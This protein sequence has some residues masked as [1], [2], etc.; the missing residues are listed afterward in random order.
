MPDDLFLLVKSNSACTRPA[1][2]KSLTAST[3]PLS[4]A[5]MSGVL[6]SPSFPSGSTPFA[7]SNRI[8]CVRPHCAALTSVVTPC[9]LGK[10]GPTLSLARSAFTTSVCPAKTALNKARSPKLGSW[11]GST[12][13][14]A[15]RNFTIPACPFRAAASRGLSPLWDLA[16][17]SASTRAIA[18]RRLTIP[19]CPFRAA[20]MSGACPNS[21]FEFAST[22]P[23]RS[24][25]STTS[26][27]PAA[28]ANARGVSPR[29]VRRSGWMSFADSNS[30]T[31]AR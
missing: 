13:G 16:S 7:S 22:F 20:A 14:I 21:S 12:V 26:S 24:N 1:E 23:V 18:R 19:I 17:A 6:P 8:I 4:A 31:T 15:R 5:I 10:L 30:F 11:F 25:S 2:S 3:C 29:S 27:A 9:L 28:A